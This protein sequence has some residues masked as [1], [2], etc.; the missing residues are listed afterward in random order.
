[1]SERP[2]RITRVTEV[3][4]HLDGRIERFEC[5]LLL[6]R[7]H[8]AVVRFDYDEELRPCGFLLPAGSHSY[9]FFWR[10]RPYQLYRMMA[11]DGRLIT[12][13][14]DVVE[15]MRLGEQEVSYQDLLLDVCVDAQGRVRVE[16]EDEVADYVRRGALTPAQ[17]E[18][19]ERT[20]ALLLLRHRAIVREAERLL[21]EAGA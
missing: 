1:M 15:D 5:E 18:R 6:R 4:R 2:V 7:R 8:L 12:H 11:P 10:R 21:V 14:F 13:R 20:R 19:I 17:R 3:K 9:G 16:D